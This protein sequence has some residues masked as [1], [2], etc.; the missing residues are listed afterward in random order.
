MA[1]EIKIINNY[2]QEQLVKNNH[3]EAFSIKASNIVLKCIIHIER[4]QF[5]RKIF[6]DLEGI[7]LK[8]LENVKMKTACIYF[9]SKFLVNCNIQEDS[10][11]NEMQK[12]I[13]P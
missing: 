11:L 7:L 1:N 12:Q 13:I 4:A 2:I 6:K 3:P 10:Y 8:V 5:L 9:I